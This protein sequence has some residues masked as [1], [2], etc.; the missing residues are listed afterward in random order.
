[1]TLAVRVGSKLGLHDKQIWLAVLNVPIA[2]TFNNIIAQLSTS[3]SL[4][5][6]FLINFVLVTSSAASCAARRSLAGSKH[7]KLNELEGSVP[8]T[9]L[10]VPSLTKSVV[11]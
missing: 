8:S 11:Y 10:L 9:Y 7:Y 4:A 5:A 3:A 1:M 2:L 6:A